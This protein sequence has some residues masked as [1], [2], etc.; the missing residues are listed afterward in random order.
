MPCRAGRHAKRGGGWRQAI[1]AGTGVI[2]LVLAGCADPAAPLERLYNSNLTHETPV[3]WW[4]ALEGG[5][6]A[7][8]RPPPPGVTDPYPNLAAV[9]PRPAPTKSTTRRALAA[10]LAAERDRTRLQTAQDP[11]VIP[12]PATPAQTSPMRASQA[13]AA[14]PVPVPDSNLSTA[15]LD[16]ASARPAPPLRQAPVLVAEPDEPMPAGAEGSAIVSGPIPALPGVPPPLPR[17]PGLPATIFA[18]A[19]PKPRPA[20]LVQFSPGS[21]TLSA[22]DEAALKTLA[23]RAAGGPVAVSAGGDTGSISPLALDLAWRRVQAI[24][25]QLT[26]DGVTLDHISSEAHAD[27]RGGRAILVD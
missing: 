15:T 10:A 19:V 6:I 9:P 11:L 25:A 5:L 7:E 18:P 23:T 13:K 20:V 26:A 4:H 27:G 24:G 22:A 21:F 16:A 17:L 14:T 1:R 8:Q 2:T 12:V 3:D